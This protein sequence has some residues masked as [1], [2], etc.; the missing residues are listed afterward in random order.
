M[1]F[2]IQGFI[3]WGLKV[4]CWFGVQKFISYLE[5]KSSYF[6]WRS[7][8]WGSKVH[9]QIGDQKFIFNLEIKSSLF[10]WR[11]KVWGSKVHFPLGD[12]KFTF[13]LEIKSSSHDRSSKVRGSKVWS[14][15]VQRSKV[16]HQLR[17]Q[18]FIGQKSG[19]QLSRDK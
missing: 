7:K 12:Q 10:S 2:K 16:H 9:F 15:N 14:S 1:E 6:S 19:A 3:R 17:V 11:S 13:D 8:V 4:H 5:I 18:K